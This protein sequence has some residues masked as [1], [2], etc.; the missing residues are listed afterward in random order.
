MRHRLGLANIVLSFFLLCGLKAEKAYQFSTNWVSDR[1]PVWQTVL[2]PFKGKPG[3]Q[4]LEIGVFEGR[5]AIW[6]MENIL[7]HPSARMTV[8]DLF[9]DDL[10]D[11]FVRNLNL[12]GFQDRTRIVTGLSQAA[13]RSLPF[14]NYDIIYVDGSHKARDVLSDA[15]L[16][17]PLLK[18]EG[19]LIFDDYSLNRGRYPAD[20]GPA[21]AI[22]AFLSAY[23]DELQ[24][25]SE[26]IQLVVKKIDN[27]CHDIQTGC[28][29][30]G[31]Y[32][33][34]WDEGVL[35]DF[36]GGKFTAL[37]R[38]ENGWARA[39]I[40]GKKP[41][42]EKYSLPEEVLESPG[43]AQFAGGLGLKEESFGKD[44]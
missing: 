3:L 42:R 26:G 9:P 35:S 16:S 41:G 25:I 14:E 27:P 10:K 28:S 15:V 18:K 38:Q 12:S 32:L 37:S 34:F 5:S 21:L 23:R 30:V 36:S 8:V 6:M 24:V 7:T 17:W 22:D 11:R 40:E 33:Y 19:I 43:F 31:H 39:L 44:G 2:G 20:H 1:T 29:P 13:L 4:Y